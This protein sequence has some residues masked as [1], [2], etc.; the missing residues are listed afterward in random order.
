MYAKE[1]DEP[2]IK[3]TGGEA[4][5]LEVVNCVRYEVF[6]CI[7]DETSFGSWVGGRKLAEAAD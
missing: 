5:A 4:D 2:L 1:R 7:L 6:V 3:R